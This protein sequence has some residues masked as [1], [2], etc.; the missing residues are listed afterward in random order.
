MQT[1]SIVG[2]EALIRCRHPVRGLVAPNEFIALASLKELPVDCL[3]ID[4]IFVQDAPYD[5]Q[6]PVL[7]GTTPA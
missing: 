4:R 5:P 3:K 7:L 1:G 2:L 6:T